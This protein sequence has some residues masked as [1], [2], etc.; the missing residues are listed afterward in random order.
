MGEGR[1]RENGS[2]GG[3]GAD[4]ADPGDQA[5]SEDGP[6]HQTQE[7]ERHD[8]PDDPGRQLRCRQA[9]AQKRAQHAVPQVQHAHAREQ[10]PHG[11][12]DTAHGSVMLPWLRQV[13]VTGPAHARPGGL[14]SREAPIVMRPPHMRARRPS[15]RRGRGLWRARPCVRRPPTW[16]LPTSRPWWFMGPPPIKAGCRRRGGDF[17]GSSVDALVIR[18]FLGGFPPPGPLFIAVDT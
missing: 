14:L 11:E 1:R 16:S 17:H 10:R 18:G 7:I 13:P 15:S 8:E 6:E 4:M 3:E 9:Q 2:Q 5:V 12:E